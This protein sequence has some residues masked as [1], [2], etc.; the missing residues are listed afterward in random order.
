[1]IFI[2]HNGDIK[3]I[4]FRRYISI[5]IIVNQT[6]VYSLHLEKPD[7]FIFFSCSA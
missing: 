3:T 1:M 2:F 5:L 6:D 4:A 7:Y